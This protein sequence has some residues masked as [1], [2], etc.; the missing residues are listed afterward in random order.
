MR[1]SEG[2]LNDR[3]QRIQV[4]AGL[5][6]PLAEL[7]NN[8]VKPLEPSIFSQPVEVELHAVRLTEW[9]GAGRNA[10]EGGKLH[11]VV[12]PWPCTRDRDCRH[13]HYG[14]LFVCKKIQVRH[15]PAAVLPEAQA[16]QYS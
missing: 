1:L 9:S 7:R 8:A 10:I 11:D 12:S 14:P 2:A 3:P 15:I 13:V 5:G 4:V 16:D 6:V